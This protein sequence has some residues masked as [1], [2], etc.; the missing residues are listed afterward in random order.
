MGPGDSTT[1]GGYTFTFESIGEVS[2]PN[3]IAA[4]AQIRLTK[5]G[6]TLPTLYPEKRIYKVQK[7]PM[8]E[9]AIETGLFRDVYVSLGEAVDAQT[10]IVRVQYKPLVTWIWWGCVLMG[11]GGILAA[12]DRRYRLAARRASDEAGAVARA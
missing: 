2:G 6:E 11:L 3:Y 9:A 5:D 12:C 10:W 4:R 7:M 8:T 1:V